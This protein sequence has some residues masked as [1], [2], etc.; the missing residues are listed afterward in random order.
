MPKSHTARKPSSSLLSTLTKY[1]LPI[2]FAGALGAALPANAN[3][4]TAETVTP[5]PTAT[6]LAQAQAKKAAVHKINAIQRDLTS[7]RQQALKS[8]P[9]LV[10]QAKALETTYKQKAED[11]GYNPDAFVAKAETLQEQLRATNMPEEE[12]NALVKEF[13]AA[14]QQLAKQRQTL[15]TDPTLVT[16]QQ[17]LQHDTLAAMKA[18]DPKTDELLNELKHLLETVQ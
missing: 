14:K 15:I 9:E 16:L 5:A 12:R 4:T 1:S 8:H 11:I 7:I 2:L 6:E 18:S 10:K 17:N 3:N 13:A